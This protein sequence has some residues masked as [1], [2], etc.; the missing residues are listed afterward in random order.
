MVHTG[1]RNLGKQVAEYYQALAISTLS[2]SD[3]YEKKRVKLIKEYKKSGRQNEISQALA[4]LKSEQRKANPTIPADLCYLV[5]DQREQYLHDMRICQEFAIENR[6][7][8]VW[9]IV[10]GMG[11]NADNIFESVHNYLDLKNNII[12][13]GAISAKRKERLIIPINMRDGS[14]IGVGKGNKDWN[15]SA[16]H[17]AGRI[18][19]RMKARE[20]LGIDEYKQSMR[21]IYTTSVSEATIDEAPMAYKPID[22][23][24]KNI[25]PTVTIEKIIRPVYNFKAVE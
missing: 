17:G 24:L 22:E 14:I 16:P 2:G 10:S 21:G 11:W 8:I 20:T 12:R 3:E 5:G 23:I 9:E 15:E 7:R 4:D 18:M 1:S 19:S 6:S 25:E 13:K